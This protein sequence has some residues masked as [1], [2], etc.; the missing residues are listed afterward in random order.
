[1]LHKPITSGAESSA[2]R[3]LKAAEDLYGRHGLY[4]VSLRQILSATDCSNKYAVQYHFGDAAGLVKGILKDRLEKIGIVQAERM[5]QF[6][7][8]GRSADLRALLDI[9]H[10]PV[11]QQVND[12]G[13]RSFARFLVAVLS[14]TE[15]VQR[16]IEI[17]NAQSDVGQLLD[18]LA[19]AVPHLPRQLFL[20]RLRQSS[21][22]VFSSVFNRLP[23]FSD[24]DCAEV[25]IDDA[26]DRAA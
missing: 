4:G 16:F 24:E 3:L 14:S 23:A 11:L 20:E 17:Y 7:S 25:L 8:E 22:M 13:E 21:I 19:E 5:N 10:R 12:H 26:I 1:M 18:M 2:S 9:C 15:G 6:R